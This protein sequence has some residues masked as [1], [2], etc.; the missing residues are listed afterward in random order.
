VNCFSRRVCAANCPVFNSL[1]SGCTCGQTSSFPYKVEQDLQRATNEERIMLP[2]SRYDLKTSCILELRFFKVWRVMNFDG[3]IHLA[4]HKD[5]RWR[6][7][8]KKEKEEGRPAIC[9]IL[10]R[11][12]P[13]AERDLRTARPSL[14]IPCRRTDAGLHEQHRELPK[15]VLD[16]MP[17]R[18]AVLTLQFGYAGRLFRQ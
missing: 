12:H 17:L 4:E 10:V 6:A 3:I 2:E 14:R 16:M 9:C 1:Y 13:Y 11:P 15:T 5:Q 8:E 7:E 18:R